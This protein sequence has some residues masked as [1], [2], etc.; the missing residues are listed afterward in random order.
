MLGLKYD[1]YGYDLECIGETP[2]EKNL[3]L[4]C[5]AGVYRGAEL[6]LIMLGKSS[7]GENK[8]WKLGTT[9]VDYARSPPELSPLLQVPRSGL[10][11]SIVTVRAGQPGLHTE[12]AIIN[13]YSG[14]DLLEGLERLTLW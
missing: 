14:K 12:Q 13:A 1:A 2:A 8:C 11:Y 10:G 9:G 6:T 5:M 7:V 3:D 4:Y